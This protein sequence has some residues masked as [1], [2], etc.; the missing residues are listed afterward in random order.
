MEQPTEIKKAGKSDKHKELQ[1]TAIQWL[2]NKG[3]SVF[4]EEVPTQNGIADALGIVTRTEKHTIYYVEAK[5][6]RSDLLCFKQKACYMRSIGAEEAQCFYHAFNKFPDL[7]GKDR[8]QD[9]SKD[10]ADCIRLRE[11]QPD[12]GIDFYYFIVSDNLKIEDTLYPEWGVINEKGEVVRRAKRRS[13]EKDSKV[14]IE[15]IAHVLVYKVFGK[16]YI[17]AV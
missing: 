3:C 5:V 2:Y 17:S 12:T 16:M 15:N 9:V 4:A 11:F 10:C 14:L 1:K 13:R 8:A 6:S 7:Y